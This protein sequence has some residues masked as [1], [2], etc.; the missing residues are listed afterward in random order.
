MKNNPI[1]PAVDPIGEADLDAL[2]AP[3]AP[4]LSSALA[5]EAEPSEKALTAIRRVAV[6]EAARHRRRRFVRLTR[7]ALS[8][9]ALF[10]AVAGIGIFTLQTEQP[11]NH[12]PAALETLL[13]LSREEAALGED[14]DDALPLSELLLAYQGFDEPLLVF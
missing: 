11:K 12:H 9:A 4:S 2:L 8:A 10:A 6:E 14:Y 3:F 7:R 5:T 1:E 13:L